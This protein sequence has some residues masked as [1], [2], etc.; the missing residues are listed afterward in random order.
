M[1]LHLLCSMLNQ[2]RGICIQHKYHHKTWTHKCRTR[3]IGLTQEEKKSAYMFVQWSAETAI[4]HIY[5]TYI[6]PAW[7][8]FPLWHIMSVHF[9]YLDGWLHDC[10]RL[11]DKQ[12]GPWLY[13]KKLAS[14]ICIIHTL[15]VLHLC[16][17]QQ[18]IHIQW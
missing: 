12:I 1:K 17:L 16:V 9:L 10:G 2:L 3:I 6:F 11:A 15:K 5:V 4:S 7:H 14:H 18:Y 8:I 13:K